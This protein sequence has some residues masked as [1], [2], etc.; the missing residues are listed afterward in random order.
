MPEDHFLNINYISPLDVN[1]VDLGMYA[2]HVVAGVLKM[3]FRT[4][5]SPLITEEVYDEFLRAC[6]EYLHDSVSAIYVKCTRVIK[7]RCFELCGRFKRQRISVAA[8]SHAG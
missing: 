2:I 7:Q 5:P 8:V 1:Q 3:F 4:L 6:G